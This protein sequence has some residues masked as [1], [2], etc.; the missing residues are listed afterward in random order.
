M[1]SL[2]RAIGASSTLPT[3]IHP[4][5]SD[6]RTDTAWAPYLSDGDEDRIQAVV[7]SGRTNLDEDGQEQ[8]HRSNLM[9]PTI[10]CLGN[11]VTGNDTQT[12]AVLRSGFQS[13][14]WIFSITNR[15]PSR[16]YPCGSFNIAAGT[17]AQITALFHNFESDFLVAKLVKCA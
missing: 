11:F 9:I 8:L 10:R 12:D 13:T 14:R 16:R 2:H 6:I 1:K 17:K 3:K 7:N 15:K 5:T 4:L